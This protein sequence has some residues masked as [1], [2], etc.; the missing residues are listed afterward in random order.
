MVRRILTIEP[1]AGFC[2]M[3]SVQLVDQTAPIRILVDYNLGVMTHRLALVT[4][5]TGFIG[6]RLV[7]SLVGQGW[8]VRIALRKRS[9]THR[10]A[11]LPCERIIL[12]LPADNDEV[13]SKAL[14]N[15]THV[16]H[17]AGLVAGDPAVLDRA[18]RVG[19]SQLAGAASKM[20]IPPIF[21]LVSSA[22]AGGPSTADNPKTIDSP[23]EPI[24][25]YGRSKLAGEIAAREFVP[26]LPL[27]IV[28][29]GIVF[30]E[31]DQEFVKI[32]RAMIRF[33]INP[34][35]GKGDQPLAMI[36]VNDLAELLIQASLKGE[37][38]RLP[39]HPGQPWDSFGVYHAGDPEP[40]NLLQVAD[41]V[42]QLF[43]GRRIRDLH[44]SPKIAYATGLISEAIGKLLGKTTTLNRDKITEGTAAGWALDPQKTMRQLGWK[45]RGKLADQLRNVCLKEWERVLQ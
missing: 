11:S 18:N 35:I 31:G 14:E 9:R 43:P 42:R 29:P 19:T 27:T 34:V 20:D 41:V 15:V 2:D 38:V 39:W 22:A 8:N 44:L 21:V 5:S 24:S 26:R 16:F 1:A 13:Y 7:A 45:P 23:P 30:G 4:G 32:L 28:R 37:R 17:V 25:I 36:E 12:D 40:L 33:S 3:P 6:S 10:I